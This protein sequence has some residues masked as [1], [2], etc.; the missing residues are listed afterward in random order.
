MPR[1]SRW[2]RATLALLAAPLVLGGTDRTMIETPKGIQVRDRQGTPRS[3]VSA[4]LADLKRCL[5]TSRQEITQEAGSGDASRYYFT[6]YYLMGLAAGVEAT[7]DSEL[8]SAL[9]GYVEQMIATARPLVR[10]GRT[11]RE[12]GPWDGNGRPR[13]LDTFQAA[14]PLARTAAIIAANPKFRVKYAA[15]CSHIVAFVA[16]SIFGYWFD[17]TSGLY[18]DAGVPWHGGVIPWLPKDQ[19]GWG[20]YPFWIDSCSHLGMIAAWMYQATGDRLYLEY[21]SRIADGFMTHV[22]EQN[23]TWIWDKGKVPVATGENLRGT[24]DTSHANREAM[25]VLTMRETGI[26]FGEKDVACLVTTLTSLIWNQDPEDPKFA[27]YLDGWNGAYRNVGPWENGNIF[28]GWAMIGSYSSQAQTVLETYYYAILAGTLEPPAA[29]N[30]GSSYG[31]MELAGILARNLV[32]PL[33]WSGARQG[34]SGTRQA[35]GRK[36]AGPGPLYPVK[37]KY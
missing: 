17:R 16:Q 11:Y 31:R 12:W 15:A 26:R 1:A 34:W 2:A 19:G 18:G 20:S 24:P 33:R 6:S 3:K 22:T 25:M 28:H 36:P 23:G 35:P 9:V 5:E 30:N 4:Y 32:S 29:A 8:M 37:I 27:N 7:G 21:A 13:Q 10:E 14:G